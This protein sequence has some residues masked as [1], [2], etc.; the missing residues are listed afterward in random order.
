MKRIVITLA[1]VALALPVVAQETPDFTTAEI[2]LGLWQRDAPGSSKFFEYRDIPQGAVLPSF[3]FS[4]RKGDYHYDFYGYD[5]TQR[6]QRYAGLFEGKT[7]KFEASYVGIPHRFGN[8]GK[9]PLSPT[10]ATATEWRMS[11]TTQAAIQT[12]IEALGSRNYDTVLPIVQ[13]TLD[14]QPSNVD[15]ALQRNRTR[16][17]FSL[18]PG[19][20]RFNIDVTYFHER[21]SGSR[22]S[23]GTSFGFN[24]VIETPEP[25]RYI[26]QDFGVN[27]SLRGDW[28]TAFAGFNLNTFDDNI[29]SFSWDNP[30][31]AS[32]STAGNAYLGPYSTTAGPATGRV[33][34]PPSNE[35]WTVKGGTTLK[36]GRS[37][38]LSGDAQVGQWKQNEQPFIGWTTNSAI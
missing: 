24:N 17:A 14:A 18:I 29:T 15:I 22:T 32:D 21:R 9:S 8:G 38:R 12:Q 11:D 7:W 1:L 10:N 35:A 5:V 27:A 28:G 3:D 16:L 31:R 4:G 6:D 30:F 25:M 26:T 2:T 33:G 13:P 37:T 23:N 34:L 20:G 36:F 19:E